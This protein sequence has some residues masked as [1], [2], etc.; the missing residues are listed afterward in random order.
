M[1]VEHILAQN[2]RKVIVHIGADVVELAD[3]GV[4]DPVSYRLA[5]QCDSTL[6]Q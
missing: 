5:A 6:W 1:T 4:F 3:E 2:P